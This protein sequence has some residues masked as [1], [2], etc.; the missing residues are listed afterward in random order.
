MFVYRYAYIMIF[1]CFA[2]EIAAFA[3]MTNVGRLPAERFNYFSRI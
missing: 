1:S 2:G 3:G